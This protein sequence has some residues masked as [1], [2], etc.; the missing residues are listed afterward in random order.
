MSAWAVGILVLTLALAGPA[1]AAAHPLPPNAA[2]TLGAAPPA[3]RDPV[4]AAE[5]PFALRYQFTGWL[6]VEQ[7]GNVLLRCPPADRR[8]A[9]A[10]SGAS[11]GNNNGYAMRWVDVDGDRSTFNSSSATFAIPPRATVDHA[12]L[13]WG[14]DLGESGGG[15]AGTADGARCTQGTTAAIPAAAPELA[16]RVRVSLAGAAGTAEDRALVASGDYVSV[17]ATTVDG[18]RTGSGRPYQAHADVTALFDGVQRPVAVTAVAVTVAN[19]QLAQGPNCSGGWTMVLVY[20]YRDGARPTTTPNDRYAPEYRTVALY[21]GFAAVGPGEAPLSV[22]LDGFH[23]AAS[24]PV[25]ARIGVVAYD[26]DRRGTGDALTVNGAPVSRAATNA[27]DSTVAGASFAVPASRLRVG[28]REPVVANALGYDT[29]AAP[30]PAGV[31][32]NGATSAVASLRSGG[33]TVVSGVILF[34]AR[35]QPLAEAVTRAVRVADGADVAGADVIGGERLRYTVDVRNIGRLALVGATVVHTLPRGLR[36]VPGTL[37]VDGR[38]I[39][40][41][42][43]GDAGYRDGSSMWVALG[44]IAPGAV[45]GV[46]FEAMVDP[47]APSGRPLVSRARLDFGVSSPG[48]AP[49]D[50]ASL[51]P[52]EFVRTSQVAVVPNRVD[53]EIAMT[54]DPG[55]VPVDGEATVLTTVTNTGRVNAR[56]IVVAERLAAELVPLD[57]VPGRGEFDALL[58]RWNVGA[59]APGESARLEVLVRVD[60]TG[61]VAAAAEVVGADQV[62]V[63]SVA[64]DGDPRSD[65]LAQ[66]TLSAGGQAPVRADLSV[67]QTTSGPMVPGGRGGLTV[68]VTNLGPGV[69]SGIAVTLSLPPQLRFVSAGGDGWSCVPSGAGGECHLMRDGLSGRRGPGDAT[70]PLAVVVDV[71]HD[72]RGPLVS[73]AV[74][75]SGVD[76]PRAADDVVDTPIE[77]DG[78]DGGAAAFDRPLLGGGLAWIGGATM[79]LGV[80]AVLLA[81]VLHRRSRRGP[82][83]ITR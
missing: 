22:A 21:D 41:V 58:R 31:V 35:V 42:S 51:G 1:A 8:C 34:S 38:R 71:A 48:P 7:A 43:D 26:G 36:P 70:A 57:A 9:S 16:D 39:S 65:D 11:A 15:D 28:P 33:D 73:R 56:G 29:W 52:G 37:A 82:H 47:A 72:A 68:A 4:P 19:V 25:D 23:A 79:G 5:R 66:T 20:S 17:R 30:V 18:L 40:D 62:D 64:A 75:T 63:D 67:S 45:R 10:Q 55:Q 83:T 32:G 44:R 27:F 13:Y 46:A 54:V 2:P 50:T 24:G 12:A 81:A 59:L 60:T 3:V 74:V 49:A 78:G 77:I 80:A 53:L 69:A 61:P 76:D 14:G 6:N